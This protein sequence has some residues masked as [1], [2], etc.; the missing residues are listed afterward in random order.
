MPI[1]WEDRPARLLSEVR[2]EHS[3]D[4]EFWG[5]AALSGLELCMKLRSS[6]ESDRVGE[7]V[8]ARRHPRYALEVDIRVYPRNTRVVRGHTVDISESGISA[9]LLVEVPIGEVVRLECKLP[10]GEVDVHALVRQRNAFRYGFQ[11]TEDA[12]AQSVIARTCRQLAVE[13]H[14]TTL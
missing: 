4:R 5:S 10:A 6:F 14:G 7:F 8:E 3:E 1:F 9:M 13:Q 11:F 2:F 12:S